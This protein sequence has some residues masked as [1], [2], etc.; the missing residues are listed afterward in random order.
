MAKKNISELLNGIDEIES[1]NKLI[2]LLHKRL[3]IFSDVKEIINKEVEEK[4]SDKPKSFKSEIKD[5]LISFLKNILL[6][7]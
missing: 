3:K 6:I 2:D 1:E 4:F 7:F 5:E